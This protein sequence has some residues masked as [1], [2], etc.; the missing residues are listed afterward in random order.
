MASLVYS[1]SN[2][3]ALVRTCLKHNAERCIGGSTPLYG[4]CT[5]QTGD[6]E[7]LYI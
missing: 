1:K 3:S 7:M 4:C 5:G 2:L 6:H